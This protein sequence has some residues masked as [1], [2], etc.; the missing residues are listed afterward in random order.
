MDVVALLDAH[1]DV[2]VA[3]KA[4]MTPLHFAAQMGQVQ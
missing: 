1:A 3:D 2:D 4:G